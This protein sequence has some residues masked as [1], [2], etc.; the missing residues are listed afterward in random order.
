V[1][2]KEKIFN[3]ALSALLLN[4]QVTSAQTDQS[5]ESKV[6]LQHYDIAFNSTLTDMELDSTSECLILALIEADPNDKWLY[7]YEYPVR[8][9]HLRRI[10]SGAK[11]DDRS[12][13]ISKIVTQNKGR[14]V[15]FT[16]E[17]DAVAD[18]VVNDFPLNSLSANAG[19][20]IAYRLAILSSSLITGKGAKKLKE[21]IER[22]Y[23]IA[24]TEAQEK[25]R[26]ENFNYVD[27]ETESEF[28]QERL[29]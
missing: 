2:S 7:S 17:V 8:C 3:I 19:L 9:A 20:A 27:E 22:D 13:H 24:K 14:K 11:I 12:T 10:D 6:L 1:Y 28:V 16:D 18:C 21:K 4:R 26:L 29:S 25:D 15:I 23:V 5:N